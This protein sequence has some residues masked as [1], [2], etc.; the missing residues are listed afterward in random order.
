MLW[1][2]N[3]WMSLSFEAISR[4]LNVSCIKRWQY[5]SRSTPISSGNTWPFLPVIM[6]ASIFHV[7]MVRLGHLRKQL[8]F[9]DTPRKSAIDLVRQWHLFLVKMFL[10]H[11][12][13]Q[14]AYDWACM[15]DDGMQMQHYPHL[16]LLFPYVSSPSWNGSLN[17]SVHF[18]AKHKS[19]IFRGLV[20]VSTDYF[21]RFP[22]FNT[23]L[24]WSGLLR[25]QEDWCYLLRL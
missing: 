8:C 12:Q 22:I 10:G 14:M 5:D 4:Q 18:L 6:R 9:P 17:I 24:K 19:C 25:Y 20:S 2:M 23:K 7:A 15:I 13:V 21:V 16:L 3:I 1:R 11:H